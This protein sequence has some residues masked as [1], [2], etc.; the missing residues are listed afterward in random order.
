MTLFWFFLATVVFFALVFA[1]LL[2]TA[3]RWGREFKELETSGVET[4]GVVTRKVEFATRGG[5]SRYIRY[6]FR[7]QFGRSHSRKT[8]AAGDAW[9]THHEGG[10]IAIVYS[11]RD[12][13]V[14]AAKFLYDTMATAAK[15]KQA[16]R[17]GSV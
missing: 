8:M 17:D 6:E 9:E 5:R 2:A 4:T 3:V 7:D 13:R 14:S 11:Q 12:P 10:P 1:R 16:R 15:E